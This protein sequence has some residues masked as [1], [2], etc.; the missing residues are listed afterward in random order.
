MCRLKDANNLIAAELFKLNCSHLEKCLP[1]GH[2][3][4]SWVIP[5]KRICINEIRQNTITNKTSLKASSAFIWSWIRQQDISTRGVYMMVVKWL[6][7]TEASMFTK[8]FDDLCLEFGKVL[9]EGYNGET[10]IPEDEIQEEWFLITESYYPVFK[11]MVND[12]L[13]EDGLLAA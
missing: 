3:G 12:L 1:K 11:E 10:D 5:A 4:L 2:D 7:D 6:L 9:E 8:Q 13:T